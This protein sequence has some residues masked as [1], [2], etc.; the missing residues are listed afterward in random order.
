MSLA[1]AEPIRVKTVVVKV[2]KKGAPAY[3]VSFGDMM[4]LILCFFIL[5]V[6]MSTERSYGMMAK[7]LGSFVIS[8]KSMGL[9]GIMNANEKQAIF[10]ETRRRFNLPPEDDPERRTDMERASTQEML[11]AETLD[12]LKP[13]PQRGR[14]AIA[15]FPT[16]E[17]ELKSTTL[18]YLDKLAV[19]LRPSL[20]EVLILE[21]HAIDSGKPNRQLA[22]R[23]ARAVRDHL[24][25]E[26]DFD[27]RRI[28]IRAW[29]GEIKAQGLHPRSVDARLI[30]PPRKD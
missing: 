16:N 27:A 21:G 2:K 29:Y 10:E 12:A 28:E 20:G 9:S 4:T 17:W 5:L 24:V 19:S 13:R 6:S 15:I 26:H 30:L 23:R 3:M 25:D 1:K 7:G 14:P 11:R 8:I 22:Q 18:E